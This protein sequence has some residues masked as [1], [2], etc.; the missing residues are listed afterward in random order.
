MNETVVFA[1]AGGALMAAGLWCVAQPRLTRPSLTERLQDPAPTE[2]K[3]QAERPVGTGWSR[4]LGAPGIPVLAALGL[5]THRTRAHLAACDRAASDYLA[6]K[7]AMAV[8][9]LLVPPVVGMMLVAAGMSLAPTWAMGAW[10]VFALVL[11]TAPDLEIRDQ[12][13]ERSDH[14]RHTVAAVC[15]LVVIALAGGAG[16]NGALNDATR[17]ADTWA[18]KRLRTSLQSATLRHEPPW[19]AL[20]DL[21]ERYQVPAATELAA[22]LRLAGADGARVRASLSAKATSLRTQHLAELEADAQSATERMSLP[23]VLMFAGFLILIGYPALHLVL[24]GM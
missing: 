20:Q 15:D 13:R 3:T 11:W 12:A 2:P 6:Q 10:M 9:G 22:S 23:V 1:A 7:A 19:S 24:T 8:L 16:V 17:T 5:P 14:M 18:M 4:T 21:G